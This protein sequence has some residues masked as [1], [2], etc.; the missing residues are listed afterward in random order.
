MATKVQYFGYAEFLNSDYEIAF[1]FSFLISIRK[2][3]EVG[4]SALERRLVW[5]KSVQHKQC[6][7]RLIRLSHLEEL[8]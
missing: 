8:S 1:T 6:K 5:G 4:L 7:M 2:G 3:R